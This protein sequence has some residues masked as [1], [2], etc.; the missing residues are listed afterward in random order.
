MNILCEHPS[1]IYVLPSPASL[2]GAEANAPEVMGRL[3]GFM[4][5]MFEFIVIDAG[6]SLDSTTLKMIEMSHDLLLVAILSLPC[7]S[8]TRR[9]L[10]SLI[11]LGYLQEDRVRLVVNR[12]IKKSDISLKDAEE[13]IKKRVFWAIPNDYRTSVA[14]INQGKALSEI[15]P[16]ARITKN[17]KQL[18]EALVRGGNEIPDK[19]RGFWKKR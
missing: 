6:Q 15:A 14:A 2:N 16:R 18:A 17:L 12:Y 7:L 8:N 4:E 9:L 1:G 3:L 5:E 13:C 10:N 11:Q 19:R